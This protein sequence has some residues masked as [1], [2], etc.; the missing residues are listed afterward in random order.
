MKKLSALILV[1]VASLASVLVV[2]AQSSETIWI[3]PAATEYKTK[4]TVI[5]MLN[6]NTATPI[7]GFTAQIR[8]DPSCLEP[9]NSTSPISGMNG[10]SVPQV[11][12]LADL[13]FASTTPQM[14]NGV[15]AEVRF[16]ALKGCQTSLTL[17]TAALVVRNE[18][19]FA[20]PVT[21]VTIV[22]NAIAMNINSAVGIP[23]PTQSGNSV[24][25]LVPTVSPSTSPVNRQVLGWSA[26]ASAL[27]T[28]IAGLYKLLGVAVR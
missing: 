5:V 9:V 7:Q 18:S 12:G 4:E 1:L 27:V 23:Q 22:Q 14:V 17:E 19:G 16:T 28:L 26:L 20:V 6:G 13:S 2:N 25:S 15:L 21:G 11:P 3:Q 10:L 8:Y 24:L